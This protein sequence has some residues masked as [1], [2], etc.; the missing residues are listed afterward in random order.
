[1]KKFLTLLFVFTSIVSAYAEKNGDKLMNQQYE[2]QRKYMLTIHEN[3]ENSI[4]EFNR[5]L[6]NASGN[7]TFLTTISGLYK[8]F[9]SSQAKSLSSKL[10]DAGL[11]A[12][13][14][15]VQSKRPLW[16]K[17]IKNESQFVRILPAQ[18]EILDFYKYPSTIGPLDPTDML[19][20][21][22]GCRQ[23]IEY[24]DTLGVV[25]QEEVFSLRCKIRTDSLGIAR[26]LN[27][28]KFLVYVDHLRFNPG[29]CDLPNDSLGI[30]ATHRIG[31][32]FD[33]RKDLQFN[34]KATLK[35]SWVNQ[36]MMVFND[37]VLGNFDITA[38]IEP[39]Q[40]DENGVFVYSYEKDKNSGK[41]IDV[42]GESLLVPRSYVGTT[43]LQNPIDAW[44]TGQYK[45]EMQISESCTINKEFYLN[46]KGR[47]DRA[48]WRAEW[49]LIRERN[50]PTA[51]EVFMRILQI[52]GGNYTEGK[53]VITM[54]EPIKTYV[55]Q[56]ESNIL[57]M[58]SEAIPT[59][60]SPQNRQ[61]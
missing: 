22:F 42:I 48:K 43:D 10:I 45:I 32:S 3:D 21:G 18:L 49:K 44:G 12:I 29:L 36:A 16:E 20:S 39:N 30:N 11:D 46:E 7:R 37:C 51:K 61:K 8:T 17:A 15:A 5:G 4:K 28:G 52:V 50:K 54:A 35:S 34:V 57:N 2:A 33:R 6:T 25:K 60:T 23:Y 13:A 41:V 24:T 26:I 19:F 59:S 27:H 14:Q 31:F 55:I 1:M 53:W 47:W 9:F 40:L 56:V 38:H 58:S